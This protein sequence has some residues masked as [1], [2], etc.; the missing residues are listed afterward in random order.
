MALNLDLIAK[1]CH[2]RSAIILLPVRQKYIML[3]HFF[4][5]YIYIYI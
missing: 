1:W 4:S 5:F 2:I 3:D